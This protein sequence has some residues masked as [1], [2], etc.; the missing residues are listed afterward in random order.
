MVFTFENHVFIYPSHKVLG[1][2][3]KHLF[4]RS[5]CVTSNQINYW[6]HVEQSRSNRA[7]EKETMRSNLAREVE[8]NR[9]NLVNE[10]E[11]NR[12][13]VAVE[14]ETNR[15]NLVTERLSRD[16]LN[17]NKQRDQ[18]QLKLNWYLANEQNRA[19]V[20][21][22]AENTRHN[23]AVESL[24][25]QRQSL[26]RYQ[27]ETSVLHQQRQDS[28]AQ[29]DA[30]TRRLATEESYRHNVAQ[31]S[32]QLLGVKETVRSN[33]ARER[34]VNRSNVVSERQNDRRLSLSER[35]LNETARHNVV[36]ENIAT[37]QTVMN[38][39]T[40]LDRVAGSSMYPMSNRRFF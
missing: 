7:N 33:K 36:S 18:Q 1:T 9:H 22:E 15:H 28:T 5:D 10:R 20:A 4:E 21:R 39:I 29:Y 25:S 34:E 23:Q 8:N 27:A 26:A 32:N 19:N 3:V 31:E 40:T 37:T 12:S 16:T 35:S 38:L 24:E 13:N 14:K 17:Y 11:T 30:I 6:K 2:W